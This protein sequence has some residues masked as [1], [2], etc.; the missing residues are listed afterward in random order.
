MLAWATRPQPES[1]PPERML[2]G[3]RLARPCVCSPAFSLFT[4]LEFLQLFRI[5]FYFLLLR[6]CTNTQ[7]GGASSGN[8]T[9]AARLAG[10][11]ST[12]GV[13]HCPGIEPGPLDHYRSFYQIFKSFGPN[14]GSNFPP[15]AKFGLIHSLAQQSV[16]IQQ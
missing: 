10:E 8:R 11:H 4:Q 7:L 1:S 6:L 12:T 14:L 3:T 16:A 2:C 13:H 5:G 15:V 9:R